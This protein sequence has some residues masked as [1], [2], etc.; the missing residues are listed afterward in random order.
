MDIQIYLIIGLSIILVAL[1][2]VWFLL[3][4][5]KKKNKQSIPQEVIDDFNEL[6]RRYAEHNGQVSHQEIL[7]DYYKSKHMN[8]KFAKPEMYNP[9]VE[10]T[11]KNELS[12][13][14]KRITP[15]Y[16]SKPRLDLNNLF[17]RKG[18]NNATNI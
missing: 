11:S 13:S 12:N 4:R 1:F 2:V 14:F 5:R 8:R 6:E 3:S 17:K 7:W 18:G 16:T 15:D 9:V 10:Q